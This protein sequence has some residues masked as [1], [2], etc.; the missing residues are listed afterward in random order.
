M[1]SNEGT[2]KK[3]FKSGIWYTVSNFIV[4]SIGFITTPIFTRMLSKAEYGGYGNYTSWMSIFTIFVT[5]NLH[6]TLISARYDYEDNLDEYIF[7]MLGL[8][9][10]TALISI[11]IVNIFPK[12]MMSLLGM[13][14]VHINAM[15]VYLLFLPAVNMFQ[16]KERYSFEY[17][18]TVFISLLIAVS[19]SLLSVI[20]VLLFSNRLTGRIFG[21]VIPTVIMGLVLSVYFF[22]K[23]RR[24][25]ISYWR[26]ALPICLPY[27]P[28]LL[29]MTFLNSVDRIMIKKIC[30]SEQTALYTLAYACGT[31]ISFLLL[32][33]NDAFSPWLGQN[34]KDG[35]YGTINSFSKK[36]ILGFFIIIILVMFLSPEVLL[37]L[38]GKSYM[39]AVYV[40]APVSMGCYCQFLYTMYVNVEQFCKRTIGMAIAS[41]IAAA[42]N[43]V[44]NSIFISIFGYIA[45]AY[46][47]LIGFICLL[48]I[49]MYLVK[50]LGK[51]S[52]YSN[53][54]V[55]I[56][57][58]IGLVIMA[59]VN[60]LYGNPMLR[61]IVLCA[62][63]CAIVA[64]LLINKGRVKSIL[65][66]IVK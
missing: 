10:I 38:G 62:Y 30:G 4:K 17:K 29:S 23:G 22:Q 3:A 48:L 24:I 40:L 55:F 7:S 12:Q 28:H 18:K 47:T 39:E 58:L 66:I 43:Y 52:V 65:R 21:A 45:A 60:F 27:I 37:I 19:T 41:A 16:I 57:V 34:L 9:S 5:L 14:L 64:F 11:A 50:R 8:S 20:L 63:V 54:F 49:H 53:S 61:Y 26:Y 42:V 59:G 46:T 31:I 13:D 2:N 25:R 1:Q 56:S 6:S 35:Q 32:A 44:L 15:L 36:Y 51:A 33:I